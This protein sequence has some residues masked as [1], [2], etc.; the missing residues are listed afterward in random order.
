MSRPVSGRTRIV[1]AALAV[2][3]V[4]CGLLWIA[5]PAQAHDQ[6]IESTPAEGEV[7]PAPPDEVMLQF[8]DEL[9][10]LG[11]IIVVTDAAEQSWTEG[12]LVYDG[13]RAMIALRDGMP[14]GWYEIRWQVV[15][16][17]GHPI[18]GIIPFA[19]GDAGERPSPAATAP[20]AAAEQ[21]SADTGE[22]GAARAIRITLVGLAGAV[23]AGGGY[24]LA[25]RLLRRRDIP[26]G[27]DESG[28]P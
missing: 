28:S 6:L 17:D 25:S 9:I 12:D 18:S 14:D 27:P 2:A 21:D 3:A 15:S 16:R 5:E 20:G 10:E 8:T 23:I 4:A 7:L 26:H 13:S 1:A 11:G 24:W 22:P 19:V